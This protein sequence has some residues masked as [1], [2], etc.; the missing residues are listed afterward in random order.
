M[1]AAVVEGEVAGGLQGGQAGLLVGGEGR[2]GHGGLD[3]FEAMIDAIQSAPV[4][5]S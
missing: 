1:A 5:Q 2:R 3:Q 4:G